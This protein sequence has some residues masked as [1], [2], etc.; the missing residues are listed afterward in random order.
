[1]PARTR[2]APMPRTVFALKIRRRQK[3]FIPS[4][5]LNDIQFAKKVP[6]SVLKPE[7]TGI[8]SDIN[9][10]MESGTRIRTNS[11]PGIENMN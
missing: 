6:E 10:S 3:N 8:K 9:I 11:G 5:N 2:A 4:K 1:M 7:W